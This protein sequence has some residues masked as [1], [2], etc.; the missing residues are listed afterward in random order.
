MSAAARLNRRITQLAVG[1]H[2]PHRTVRIRLTLLYSGLILLSGA[3]L[4]AITYVLF[5]QATEYTKPHLPKIPHTPAIARVQLP[6][7]PRVLPQLA[8][9]QHR[10]AKAVDQLAQVRSPP[11]GQGGPRLAYSMPLLARDQHQLAGDQ[12][13]LAQAVHQLAGAVHQVAQAGSVQAAQRAADSHQLLVDS[14]TALAIMAALALLAGWLVAGRVLQPLQDSYRAQRQFVANASHEL[15]APLTRQRAMI[16]VALAGPEANVASLRHAHERVLASEQELEQLI[17]ALLALT[18]GQAGLQRRE[19]SDLAVL[20]DRALQAQRS[21]VERLS[22]D[23]DA[24]LHPAP[25]TGDRR[26]LEALIANLIDNAIRHNVP[27]G[28]VE[29]STGTRDRRTFVSVANGGQTIPPDQIQRL[30]EPFQRLVDTR[31]RHNNGHGL[32]LSIVQAIADVHRAE[33]TARAR[34]QGGLVIELSFP[35]AARA[36]SGMALTALTRRRG[37]HAGLPPR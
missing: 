28:Q 32:G 23:V 21:E 2:L 29:I 19:R 1:R 11:L 33:L 34:P 9:D 26:L 24:A 25:A 10:L 15:R 12:R 13:Q 14:G 16:E 30:F 5:Q 22:L 4:V 8:Q 6:A 3:A 35:P 36:G 7:F 17:D 20:A 27:G 37:T 31:T 18:R